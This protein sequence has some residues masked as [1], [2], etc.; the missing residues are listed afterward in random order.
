MGWGWGGLGVELPMER[1]KMKDGQ[2]GE[3]SVSG[4][5]KQQ[6]EESDIIYCEY[7]KSNIIPTIKQT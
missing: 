1:S 4:Q 5:S 6:Q 3:L 7:V 2:F